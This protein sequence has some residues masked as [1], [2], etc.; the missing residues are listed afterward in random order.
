MT[1]SC[2]QA[3]AR[4]D[5]PH[6]LA[7][8]E[9]VALAAHL[10]NCDACRSFA[11]LEARIAPAFAL[12]PGLR[13]SPRLTAAL[14]AVPAEASRR[15]AFAYVPLAWGSLAAVGLVAIVTWFARTPGNVAQLPNGNR[16]AL[17]TAA[18]PRADAPGAEPAAKRADLGLSLIH[19]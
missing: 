12:T 9:Q 18:S 3:R 15:R 2:D 14:M 16:T 4:I 10:A 11:A 6:G 19:I 13:P 5:A 17:P 1:L 7:A 8:A